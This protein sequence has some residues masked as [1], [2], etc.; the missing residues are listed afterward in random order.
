MHPARS[1][2]L[3]TVLSGQGFG[4]MVFLG[5]G[6]PQV[7]GWTAF[8]A[9]AVAFALAAGG[10]V[11]S[12]FH[13]GHP[14][15]AI[16]AFREW[17]TSWLSR[18]AWLASAALALNGLFAL[19]LIFGLRIA[20]L[21]WLAAL[22]AITTVIAT[23]MI[24]ASL[25]TV[26]RWRQPYTPVLFA[27]LALS[28]GALNTGERWIGLLLLITGGILQVIAWL[29]GDRAL[30]ESGTSIHSA[31]GLGVM[32]ETRSFEAPHTGENY[33]TREMVFVLGRKHSTKLRL[34]GAGLAF[35]GPIF[36]LLWPGGATA[37]LAAPFHLLGTCVLR[38][39]F[40][41]EAEHVVGLY[42]GRR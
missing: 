32:G 36:L 2:I 15:R 42:Y 14:E 41:A 9:Y 24:Y 31:T 20:P 5:L 17:R 37:F 27:L 40:F 10:L 28:G 21:G 19:C 6:M 7:T 34:I 26:P 16:K 39:L 29:R 33:L 1:L 38:W 3:F 11:S 13:L 30:A 25:K 18:E 35:A 8:G 12:V 4:M 22:M 23:S